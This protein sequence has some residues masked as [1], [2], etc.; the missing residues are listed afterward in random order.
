MELGLLAVSEARAMVGRRIGMHRLTAEPAAVDEI[1]EACARLPLALAVAAARAMIRPE[2]PLAG[3]AEELRGTRS[4]L[5]AFAEEDETTDVRAVLSWS[6]RALAAPAARLF[7]LIGLH[8][9]PDL[10]LPAAAA[11]SGEPVDATRRQLRA[12]VR[13]HLLTEQVAGRYT[14]HDLLRAYAGELVHATESPAER[15]TVR[16]RMLDHYVH[17]AYAAD[18]LLHPHREPLC[19]PPPHADVMVESPADRDHALAWFA[20]EHHVLVRAVR[21]AHDAGLDGDAWRLAWTLTT[22][23]DL[24]GHWHDWVSTQRIALAAVVGTGDR[25]AQAFAHRNL[26]LAYAQLSEFDQSNHHLGQALAD[27]QDLDD[28][29]GQAHTHNTLAR[30]YGSQGRPRAALHE[31]TRAIQLFREAG[32][33][34]NQ[35]RALNNVGW[36]HAQLGENDQ[37]LSRCQEALVLHQRI[38]D[39]Y[40]EANTRDSLGLVHHH[41]G[42]YARAVDDYRVA[43][44]RWREVGDRYN[45]AGTLDRLGDTYSAIGD[46]PRA[47]EVWEQALTML[48]RLDHADAGEIR[49]KLDQLD[50][51]RGG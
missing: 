2:M 48:T 15:E 1:V 33:D 37:A 9:G 21:Q 3:L 7:R 23:F 42:Q 22:Y 39:R 28:A 29:A 18:R 4:G 20:A 13:A 49:R 44:D 19:L 43:L 46:S 50:A 36:Y 6:Y 30:V 14:L 34:A 26:G 5:D 31:T 27:Y 11:L 51:G 17:S 41:L 10:T 35:A 45:E 24:Q 16:R 12:L 40:G 32:H 38:G 47:R 8:T 25:A